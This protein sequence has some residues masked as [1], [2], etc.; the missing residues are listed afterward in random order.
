MSV[1]SLL[2]FS[3]CRKFY[4]ARDLTRFLRIVNMCL[5]DGHFPPRGLVSR[6]SVA[7]DLVR[8]LVYSILPLAAPASVTIALCFKNLGL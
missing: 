8:G 5:F 2:G 6:R 3:K 1:A 7:S 4:P